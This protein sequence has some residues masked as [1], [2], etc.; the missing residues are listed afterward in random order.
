[1]K[2]D[3]EKKMSIDNKLM[4]DKLME[5]ALAPSNFLQLSEYYQSKGIDLGEIYAEQQMFGKQYT[6]ETNSL[7]VPLEKVKIHF[8]RKFILG[9]K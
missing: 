7:S 3:Y 5:E 9:K 2:T 6:Q 8:Y 1:M 4:G